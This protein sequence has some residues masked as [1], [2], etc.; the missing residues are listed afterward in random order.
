MLD[1]VNM[2]PVR[3]KFEPKKTSVNTIKKYG[4][5]K[6]KKTHIDAAQE[7]F[8]MSYKRRMVQYKDLPSSSIMVN[9]G[10]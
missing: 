4:I 7:R 5:F 1:R 9:K 10:K 6:P 2:V 3:G 8:S